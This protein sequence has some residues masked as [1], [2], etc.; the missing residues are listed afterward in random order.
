MLY[1]DD[2]CLKESD[3]K[4]CCCNCKHQVIIYKHPSNRDDYV[5]GSIMDQLGYLCHIEGDGNRAI[6]SD[7]KHSFCEAYEKE[8]EIE[9]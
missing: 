2:N 7:R 3:W 8:K 9:L 5:N 1:E 4:G 6:F